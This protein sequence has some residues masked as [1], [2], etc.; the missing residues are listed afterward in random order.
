M[1]AYRCIVSDRSGT[2]RELI[3]YAHSAEDASAA[4]VSGELFLISI[5]ECE[6][7]SVL[8]KGSY[9]RKIVREFT[10]V[11]SMLLDSGL[12]LREALRIESGIV[13]KGGL[14][15]LVNEILGEIDK[16]DSFS[17][18]ISRRKTTF[19]PLYAG[20]VRIGE[21]I[22]S[23]EAVFQRLSAYLRDR[24]AFRD[25]MFGALAY[26]AL[27]LALALA[28]TAIIA[29]FLMPQM[30]DLFKE[31]GGKA[32]KPLETRIALASAFFNVLSILSLA[33]GAGLGASFIA[34]R[35]DERFAAAMDRVI[36]S[37]PVIG[38]LMQ[39][40][41]SLN[42]SFAMETLSKGGLPL[43]TALSEAA[44][45]VGNRAYRAAILAIRESVLKGE[46]LSAAIAARRELP[47]YLGRWVSVGERSG[48]THS[49]FE[50]TRRYFQGEIDLISS[51][52]VVLVEPALIVFVGIIILI[53]VLNFV[54]PLFSLYGSVI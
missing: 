1:K 18:A 47:E 50:Q 43:E 24:K 20:M 34:R 22:G 5:T 49:V 21:K 40:W 53:L 54:I 30:V 38:K 26:P 27:V 6:D 10:D 8:R 32:A 36:L 25:K 51:R 23:M 14:S 39:S 2:K 13:S 42:L 44:T 3:K 12:D 9:P 31:L 48:K 28:G 52:L 29:F 4:F 7:K 11:T 19:S 41:D 37:L 45:A 33:F 16:G 46:S 15:S 35:F 17:E